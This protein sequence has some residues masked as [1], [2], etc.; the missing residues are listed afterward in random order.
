VETLRFYERRGLLPKPHRTPSGHRRYGEGARERLQ[1]IKRAQTLGFSLPEIAAL[2]DA[3]DDPRANCEDVCAV[4]QVKL[5]HV[6]RLLAQ[7]RAQRR[8]LLR[9]RDACPQVRPLRECPVVEELVAKPTS[10][11]GKSR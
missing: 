4:V 3:M 6:D 2:L 7:L 10:G 11:R 9:L 1:L 8:H 5:D